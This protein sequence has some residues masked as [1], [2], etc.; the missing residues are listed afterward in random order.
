MRSHDAVVQAAAAL[1]TVPDALTPGRHV[2]ITLLDVAPG[3]ARP[4]EHVDARPRARRHDADPE[5]FRCHQ[6]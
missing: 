4:A 5:A 1:G 6:P 2:A 3:H